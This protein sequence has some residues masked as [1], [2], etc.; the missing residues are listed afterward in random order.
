MSFVV[1]A[2]PEA[3]I[4]P[5]LLFVGIEIAR[6]AFVES[7]REHVPAV[8]FA[9]IPAVGYLVLTY[10]DSLI[11]KLDPSIL[12]PDS[13]TAEQILLR[14]AGHGFILTSMLWGGIL[15]DLIDG[16]LRSAAV[17][18]LICAALTMFGLIHSVTPSGEIY[19]PWHLGNNLV[20]NI[21]LGY[22]IVGSVL[23]LASALSEK[24]LK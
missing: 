6:Q 14:A 18:F 23:L 4:T 12:L 24:P 13:L 22:G 5:I 9:M 20:W 21:S 11:G 7:R 19:I 15:A 10:A 2:I 8:A 17:S 1:E 3:V 16:K